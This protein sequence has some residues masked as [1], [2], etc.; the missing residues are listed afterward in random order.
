[1]NGFRLTSDGKGQQLQL[2]QEAYVKK[3][4]PLSVGATFSDFASLRMK[5]AWLSNSLPDVV[6]EVAQSAQVTVDRFKEEPTTVIKKKTAKSSMLSPE[7]SHEVSKPQRS[8]LA[9]SWILRCVVL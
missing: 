4:E 5:L 7:C 1:M 8:I 6:L 2:N 3:L 9:S